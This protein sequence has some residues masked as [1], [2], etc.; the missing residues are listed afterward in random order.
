MYKKRN[1]LKEKDVSSSSLRG[2]YHLCRL[3][4][5]LDENGITLT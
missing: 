5:F 4:H 2:Y 1:Y 3:E